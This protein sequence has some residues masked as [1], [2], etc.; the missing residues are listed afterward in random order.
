MGETNKAG[1]DL[2]S[3][4][5]QMQDILQTSTEASAYANRMKGDIDSAAKML[6]EL[7]QEASKASVGVPVPLWPLLGPPPLQDRRKSTSFPASED[8]EKRSRLGS[9]L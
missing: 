8:V 4:Q 1:T 9:F 7:V 6:H 2:R 5:D 3:R